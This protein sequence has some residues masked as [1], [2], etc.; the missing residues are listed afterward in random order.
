MGTS[1]PRQG[2][3][4]VERMGA[5]SFILY[6]SMYELARASSRSSRSRIVFQRNF[7]NAGVFESTDK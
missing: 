3:G 7:I 2:R 1:T 4:T 5:Y 6:V